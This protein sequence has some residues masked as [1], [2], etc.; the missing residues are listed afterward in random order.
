ML[1]HECSECGA[2]SINRIAADDDPESI[3]EAFNNSLLYGNQ[4]RMR[5]E[6]NEIA[7]LN[8]EDAEIVFAQLYG[9]GFVSQRVLTD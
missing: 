5:C 2:L 3:M 9:Q 6:Q 4:I 8:A 1:I 7:L